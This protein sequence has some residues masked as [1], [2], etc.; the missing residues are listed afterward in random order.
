MKSSALTR[1]NSAAKELSLASK[2]RAFIAEHVRVD[3][4]SITANSHLSDDLG[5]DPLDVIE[6]T[7]LLEDQFTNG[8]VRDEAVAMQFV[9]DLVSH[10]KCQGSTST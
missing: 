1:G 6:L 8:G 4:E 9:R 3:V 5:L 10:L 2:V 7:I